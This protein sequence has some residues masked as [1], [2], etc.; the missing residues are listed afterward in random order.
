MNEIQF[1]RWLTSIGVF[2]Q[3]VAYHNT[4]DP[5]RGFWEYTDTCNNRTITIYDCSFNELFSLI[6]DKTFKDNVGEYQR[7]ISEIL[8]L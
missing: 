4:Y 8:E 1:M 7:K 6:V 5:I 3:N 2:D